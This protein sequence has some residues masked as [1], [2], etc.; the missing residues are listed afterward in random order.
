MSVSSHRRLHVLHVSASSTGGVAAIT[1]GYVRDQIERGW[2][3]TVACPTAGSLGYDARVAGARVQWWSSGGS[4]DPAQDAAGTSG[5]TM[6]GAASLA[7]VAALRAVVEASNP[8]V[9]HLHGARAGMVGRLVVRDRVPTLLQPHGWTFLSA[10]GS[11]AASWRW[12]RFASRWT[13]ELIYASAGEQ[14]I[15][16]ENGISRPATVIADG[17]DL[18]RFTAQGDTERRVARRALGLPEART[19]VCVGRLE[20]SKGQQDLLADW[21]SVREDIPDAELLLVGDGPDRGSLMRQA[22]K[23]H[24][25]GMPGWRSD[26][27]R[28]YAAADVVVMPSRWAGTSLVAL[29]AMACSR[30]VVVTDVAG[31]V[32]SVAPEAGA[33]VPAG[34]GPALVSA[35][36]HRLRYAGEAEDEGWNGR[37]HVESSHDATRTAHDVSRVYLRLVSARR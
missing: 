15:G 18:A 5:P 8:D 17:V 13:T 9:V 30:S 36:V 37:L 2:H 32:E 22:A 7:E 16:E 12:E 31:L 19:V 21:T 35:L 3:V 14:S 26:V 10:G 34:A 4:D 28:W 33:I 1:L 27:E 20:L 29:E 6:T 23:L 24:G 11:P 25:V